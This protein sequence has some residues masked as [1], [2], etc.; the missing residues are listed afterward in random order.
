MSTNEKYKNSLLALAGSISFA[1]EASE[2]SKYLQFV[3]NTIATSLRLLA[4][5]LVDPQISFT[6]ENAAVSISNAYHDKMFKIQSEVNSWVNNCQFQNSLRLCEKSNFSVINSK[7][8]KAILDTCNE[9]RQKVIDYS[10]DEFAKTLHTSIYDASYEKHQDGHYADAIESAF[11]EVNSRL[12]SIYKNK[13]KKELDG[14]NLFSAC[15][16][17]NETSLLRVAD[18]STESGKNE[19]EGFRQILVGAW[20]SQR[21]P[22]AHANITVGRDE[23]HDCLALASLI[24]RKIDIAIALMN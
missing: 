2:A 1:P 22:K 5:C 10:K 7:L 3:N 15:F 18:L 4:T 6:D 19:Q 9:I 8:N 13:T 23:S 21:S 17:Q 14:E 24:M 16:N 11:K 12:K 20:R